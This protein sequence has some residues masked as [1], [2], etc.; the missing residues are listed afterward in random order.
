MNT[1]NKYTGPWTQKEAR[2]LLTRTLFGPNQS[3][4]QQAISLG[5]DGTMQ[6][7]MTTALGPRP[8][9]PYEPNDPEVPIGSTWI[10]ADATPGPGL[11]LYRIFSIT[12]WYYLKLQSNQLNIQEKMV[13]FWHNHF[14]VSDIEGPML[15]YNYFDTLEKNALGNFRDLAKKITINAGMLRYLNGNLNTKTTLNENYARE[16]LE[17]FTIGKGDLA[18]PGDYTTFTEQDVK[19]IAHALTGWSYTTPYNIDVTFDPAKHD[20]TTKQLS[21]RFNNATIPNLGNKEYEKVVDIIFQQDECSRFISRKLYRWFVD[22]HITPEVEMNIIESMAQIIRDDDYNIKNALTAL[23][24]SEHFYSEAV[25][26]CMIKSPLDFIMSLSNGLEFPV[27]PALLDYYTYY[28]SLWANSKVMGQVITELPDVAGWKAYYQEPQFY[29]HWI[30]SV[31]LQ[32]RK[33]FIYLFIQS[34]IKVNNLTPIRIPVMQ[35]IDQLPDPSHIDLLI[36][37]LSKLIYPYSL[38]STQLDY[39]QEVV[40]N[41]L[42]DYEWTIEYNAYKADPNNT[43]LFNAIDQK[44]RNLFSTMLNLPEFNLH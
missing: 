35:I 10:N 4:I 27:P 7:L 21:Y 6:A 41:G 15:F 3:M 25:Y 30:N 16:L 9:N 17:L 19:A 11:N 12:A 24:F 14:V 20:T 8:L 13:L 26:G 22:Y 18:G 28:N 33:R 2:H 31:S 38:T 44:I 29:R 42:P 32:E 43:N 37:D 39:L 34:G 36:Q 5:L 40:L 1:L 23:L